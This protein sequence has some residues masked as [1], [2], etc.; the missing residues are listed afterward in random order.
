MALC[1]K[2]RCPLIL[3]MVSVDISMVKIWLV[4]IFVVIS[5]LDTGCPAKCVHFYIIYQPNTHP[6]AKFGGT[7]KT[8]TSIISVSQLF[9]IPFSFE[10][11]GKE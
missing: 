8:L 6:N 3:N 1:E 9:L 2:T 4:N 10:S 5:S 11:G 7:S